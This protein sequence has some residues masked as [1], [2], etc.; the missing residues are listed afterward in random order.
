MKGLRKVKEEKENQ[1]SGLEEIVRKV[2]EG[3]IDLDEENN[4]RMEGHHHS[5]HHHHQQNQQ[6]QQHH[7]EKKGKNSRGNKSSNGSGG[8]G[9][10]IISGPI[11]GGPIGNNG[12]GNQTFNQGLQNPNQ[13]QHFQHH[14][15]QAYVYGDHYQP[16]GLG[17]GMSSRSLNHSLD[18]NKPEF[19]PSFSKNVGNSNNH[20]SIQSHLSNQRYANNLNLNSELGGFNGVGGVGVG[21]GNG[22]EPVKQNYDSQNS[23]PQLNQYQQ[24]PSHNGFHSQPGVF[25]PNQ[26]SKTYSNFDSSDSDQLDHFYKTFENRRASIPGINHLRDDM[27]RS[28]FI[29]PNGNLNGGG[30]ESGTSTPTLSHP[31][32]INNPSSNLNYSN[33]LISP[34]PSPSTSS[35]PN[36]NPNERE[37]EQKRGHSKD[38]RKGLKNQRSTPSLRGNAT[39]PPSTTGAGAGGNRKK[40]KDSKTVASKNKDGGIVKTP[41]L[42]GAY[43]SFQTS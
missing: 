14:L 5:N 43:I 4:R 7:H 27:S 24:L 3:E 29:S 11:G 6:H 20:P 2:L 18:P 32:L 1:I 26:T 40:G 34:P 17:M 30:R 35:N 10:R 8:V 39:S 33:L 15:Q 16:I 37:R 12:F 13:N 9:G 28:G 21:I 38:K 31:R 41:P 22:M 42:G 23:S 19:V 36:P 25:L